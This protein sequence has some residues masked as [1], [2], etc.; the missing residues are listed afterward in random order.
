MKADKL[1][2]L[3]EAELEEKIKDLQEE[4]FNLKFQ[5]A[6]G[7][8][9]NPLKIRLVR[10]DVARAKTLLWERRLSSSEGRT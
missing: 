1:R 2:E 6:I 7:Q 4:L 9:E 10:R 8:I 5:L 3:S